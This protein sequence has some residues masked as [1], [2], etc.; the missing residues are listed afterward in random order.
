MWFV[1]L[2]STMLIVQMNSPVQLSRQI[3]PHDHLIITT[4][5]DADQSLNDGA[6][7]GYPEVPLPPIID[8]DVWL[9][10]VGH[11]RPLEDPDNGDGEDRQSTQWRKHDSRREVLGRSASVGRSRRC[12]P[13]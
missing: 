3:P 1:R 2:L 7:S 13:R 11:T 5:A 9:P 8:S 6:S 12:S 4:K 10:G